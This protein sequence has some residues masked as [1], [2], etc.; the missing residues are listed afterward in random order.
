LPKGSALTALDRSPEMISCVWPGDAPG[1][2]AVCGDW[3]E[4]LLELGP[5]DVAL[6]DCSLTSQSWPEGWRRVLFG[7]RRALAPDGLFLIRI[8][9]ALE[10]QESAGEVFASLQRGEIGSF[11]AFKLR[12]AMSLQ[13]TPEEGVR[14][15]EI[16]Q[17]W[18]RTLEDAP[19]LCRRAGFSE[20]S[21]ATIDL[22]R[23]SGASLSFPTMQQLGQL[24]DE[25]FA[26]AET[27]F[28]GGELGERH[29]RLRL[30]PRSN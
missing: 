2:Q 11:H 14:L 5:F 20:D 3:K 1:R 23:G 4:L 28:G 26:I 24:L 29:P 8:R 9:T 19:E 18:S 22:Y 27:A 12:L 10:P 13:R 21:I 7:V 6:G 15:S 25:Q 17:C 30:R 16:W